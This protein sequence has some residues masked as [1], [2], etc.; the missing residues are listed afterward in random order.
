MAWCRP[1]DQ[2]R[3]GMQQSLTDAECF[4]DAKT[5]NRGLHQRSEPKDSVDVKVSGSVNH[6][7]DF[8]EQNLADSWAAL[9]LGVVKP[10]RGEPGVFRVSR[11]YSV[12]GPEYGTLTISDAGNGTT[13]MELDCELGLPM[14]LPGLGKTVL[15][16]VI[17]GMVGRTIGDSQRFLDDRAQ[18]RGPSGPQSHGGLTA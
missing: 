6:P 16:K 11:G 15:K 5:D 10:K 14:K 7:V 17:Q 9:G 1:S 3:P 13:R 18:A 8:V 2:R 4:L 12:I